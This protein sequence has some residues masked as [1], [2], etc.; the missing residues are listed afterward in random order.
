[1]DLKTYIS[2]ERGRAS[3]LAAD[4]GVSPSYVSQLASGDSPVSAARA[5]AIEKFTGG[6]V[7][8]KDSLPLT[9]QE[10]WPDL[11]HRSALSKKSKRASVITTP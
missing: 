3:R 7:T 6:L 8:R 5:M 1:M 10:I 9:W 2:S 11:S 4:L